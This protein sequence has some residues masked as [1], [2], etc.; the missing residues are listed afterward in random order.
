MSK[1]S[2]IEA[3]THMSGGAVVPDLKNQ[4]LSTWKSQNHRFSDFSFRKKGSFYFVEENETTWNPPLDL[5]IF[6]SSSLLQKQPAN[7]QWQHPGTGVMGFTSVF[8]ASEI[9]LKISTLKILA[10]ETSIFEMSG[11]R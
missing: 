10:A 4:S 6:W 11:S 8:E 3:Q 5:M 9:Y 2:G 7:P 1:I